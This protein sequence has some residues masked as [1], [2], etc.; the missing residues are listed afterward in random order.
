MPAVPTSVTG[1]LGLRQNFTQPRRPEKLKNWN[2]D[3]LLGVAATR[4]SDFQDFR[5]SPPPPPPKSCRPA[6]PGWRGACWSVPNNPEP[7]SLKRLELLEFYLYDVFRAV[8]NSRFL[9]TRRQAYGD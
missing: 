1:A 6:C 4:I 2:P 3:A 7:E 9:D 8:H 5:F